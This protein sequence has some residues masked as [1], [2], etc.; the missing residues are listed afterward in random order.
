M[1]NKSGHPGPKGN[2]GDP[3]SGGSAVQGIGTI[4][5]GGGDTTQNGDDAKGGP[6]TPPEVLPELT[7]AQRLEAEALANRVQPVGL[8]AAIERLRAIDEDAHVLWRT[9]GPRNS[10][11]TELAGVLAEV[12]GQRRVFIVQAFSSGKTRFWSECATDWPA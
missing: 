9:N 4:M 1:T 12:E 2:A 7:E 6:A 3:P 11:I 8:A 5:A 10:H